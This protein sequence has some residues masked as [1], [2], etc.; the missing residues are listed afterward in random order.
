M[1]F[2][3][4]GQQNFYDHFHYLDG[5]IEDFVF[6]ASDIEGVVVLSIEDAKFIKNILNSTRLYHYGKGRFDKA[7]KCLELSHTLNYRIEQAEKSNGNLK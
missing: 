5:T 2:S 7:D 6:D 4:R 1:K 3:K